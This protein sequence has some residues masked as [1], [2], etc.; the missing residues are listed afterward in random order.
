MLSYYC[1][2]ILDLKTESWNTS[3]KVCWNHRLY[4]KK[5]KEKKRK[6]KEKKRKKVQRNQHS[7]C[8][9]WQKLAQLPRTKEIVLFTFMQLFVHNTASQ[10]HHLFYMYT[11]INCYILWNLKWKSGY[12][13]WK[14]IVSEKTKTKIPRFRSSSTR[15]TPTVQKLS[16]TCHSKLVDRS[17]LPLLQIF[18]M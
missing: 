2:L 6:E 14:P 1:W 10:Y 5:K 8:S 18:T 17:N 15:I 9:K 7:Y 3:G 12:L 4:Q 13:V 16:Q 11:C